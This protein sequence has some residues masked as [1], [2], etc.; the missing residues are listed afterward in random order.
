MKKLLFLL[1]VWLLPLFAFGSVNECL[2][3]VYFANGILTDEGNATANTILL[4]RAI[5]RD[6]YHLNI[7]DYN[8][9]IGD[10]YKAYNST[11]GSYWD[12]IESAAQKWGFQWLKDKLWDTVHKADLSLQIKH[13]KESIRMGH[14]VLAVAHSQGNLFTNDAYKAILGD[15]HDWWMTPYFRIV[16]VASPMH[17]KITDDTPEISWDNDLVA[18]LGLDLMNGRTYNPVRKIKWEFY[19]GVPIANR[20]ARPR[21]NYV[22]SNKL[23]E[24]YK[25]SWKAVEGLLQKFDSN[26]HAF[27]FYMGQPIKDGDTGEIFYNPFDENKTLQT[28][29]AKTKIM[30]AINNQLDDLEKVVSQYKIKENLGCLCKDKYVKME[31]RFGDV[32]LTNEIAKYK[33]RNFAGDGKGKV[34]SVGDQYVR[35]ACDGTKIEELNEG[36]TCY[37]LKDDASNEIGTITGAADIAD[38]LSGAV[39]VALDWENT[40][41]DL[42]L[43]VRWDA[44]E[45]DVKD[46]ECPK[47]HWVV[48]NKSSVK[49]GRYAVWVNLKALNSEESSVADNV[50]IDIQALGTTM[51]IVAVV[52]NESDY[53]IGHVA[54]I[55]IE[56]ADGRYKPK[57]EFIP[58]DNVYIGGGGGGG[59]RYVPHRECREEDDKYNCACM[60]C[61][62]KIIPYLEQALAGP[63]SGAAFKLYEASTYGSGLPLYTGETSEGESILTAGIIKV[64]TNFTDTLDDNKLYLIE[65]RG[66]V[67]VDSDDDYNLDDRSVVN[68]G[69]LRALMLGK[70]LKTHGYKINLLTEISYQVLK[71]KIGTIDDVQL[72]TELDDISQYLLRESIYEGNITYADVINWLP[73]LD[74]K[75]LFYDYDERFAP[76]VQKIYEDQDIYED[77]LALVYEPMVSPRIKGAY[78]K[79]SEDVQKNTHVGAVEIV[80]EGNS[81]IEAFTLSGEGSE[82]FRIDLHGN[83]YVSETASIDYESCQ[84]YHLGATASNADG[85]TTVGVT[86]DI[87]DIEDAPFAKGFTG[88]ILFGNTP[89]QTPVAKIIFDPGKAPIESMTL[90]GDETRYFDINASGD[91]TVSDF[92]LPVITQDTRFHFDV[93]AYN[94]YGGSQPVG[95]TLWVKPVKQ[96]PSLYGFTAHVDEHAP[97]NT[98]IHTVSFVSGSA[99]VDA[100][101]LSG[102][103]S[104]NFTVNTRGE[105]RVSANADLDYERR[106]SYSLSLGARNQFGL[107]ENVNVNILLNDVPDAATLSPFQASITE[108]TT[109]TEPLG[110]VQ[111]IRGTSDIVLF[112]LTGDGSEKFEVDSQGI[113]RVVPGTVFDYEEKSLYA[114]KIRAL[115]ASGYSIPVDFN[116]VIENVL[117]APELRSRTWQI[118]ENSKDIM[119]SGTVLVNEGLSPVKQMVVRD[120]KGN[121]STD[122]EVGLDGSVHVLPDAELDYE[123][124]ERGAT[125]QFSVVAYNDQG[126]SKSATLTINLNNLLDAPELQPFTGSIDENASSGTV[127]GSVEYN[128]GL[129]DIVQMWLAVPPGETYDNPFVIDNAGEIRL[130]GKIDYETRSNYTLFAFAKNRQGTS[131]PAMVTITIFDS[132]NDGPVLNSFNGT[133]S[134][135][136]YPGESVGKITYQEG[137]DPIVSMAL[138]GTGSENFKVDERG[139]ITLAENAKLDFES[140]EQYTLWAQAFSRGDSSNIVDV[141][142]TVTDVNEN[143]RAGSGLWANAHANI[144]RLEEDGNRTLLFTESTSNVRGDYNKTGLF[145]SHRLEFEDNRFYVYEINGGEER[146]IDHNGVLDE[147]STVNLGILHAVT[148]GEWVRKMQKP[149]SVNLMTDLFYQWLKDDID[150]GNYA[151]LE[152][153]LQD[154]YNPIIYWDIDGEYHS[155]SQNRGDGRDALV[156]DPVRNS[157][158]WQSIFGMNERLFMQKLLYDGEM[159]GYETYVQNTLNNRYVWHLA[160]Q[161]SSVMLQGSPYFYAIMDMPGQRGIYRKNIENNASML[162]EEDGTEQLVVDETNKLLYSTTYGTES[163]ESLAIWDTSAEDTFAKIAESTIRSN[164]YLLLSSNKEMLFGLSRDQVEKYMVADLSGSRSNRYDV[165]IPSDINYALLSEDDRWLYMANR[166]V[167]LQIYNAETMALHASLMLSG[168]IE[169]IRKLQN[170]EH[171]GILWRDASNSYFGLVNIADKNQPELN[172]SLDLNMSRVHAF[173]LNR[174]ET[175][176]FVGGYQNGT[177][178][179]IYQSDMG[180]FDFREITSIPIE[181]NFGDL[182]E[183]YL[184]EPTHRLIVVGEYFMYIYDIHDLGNAELIETVQLADIPS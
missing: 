135:D 11:H 128:P 65:A 62:A 163:E 88:G 3:D 68:K 183:I 72:R 102:E 85:N 33:I 134:E 89:S 112:E 15:S 44:G 105:V 118:D 147:N 157:G 176:L 155:P 143:A 104:E 16:S 82:D 60:P 48:L 41:A 175:L 87:L 28:D 138:S 114:L 146:D 101:V 97:A 66:G 137:L 2:T 95:I 73:T 78:L 123:D 111:Y 162:Q 70:D 181:H 124:Y 84:T 43:D 92:G 53:N 5:Q 161:N 110:Q 126:V 17:F 106:K 52:E 93:I 55:I 144:Y 46:I 158:V 83:I 184:Y 100:F 180:D 133:I 172:Y 7:K 79:V 113:V 170:T 149:L 164:S 12:I 171:L 98:L 74:K 132:E 94:R 50:V 150:S 30:T 90:I 165:Q 6:V 69:S 32:S 152:E 29:I 156:Y 37:I 42:D 19:D 63:L 129:S 151:A 20:V 179:K 121:I 167:G 22:R 99:P 31:H 145:A 153:K 26:V 142:I 14:R 10:V 40:D 141:N 54:D 166:N 174:D 154:S 57:V 25:G 77:A 160:K 86:I 109:V 91:I 38:V 130:S 47:E 139:N 61:S 64:D 122:I 35:A 115:N 39:T 76:V 23:N 108:N 168:I 24:I 169:R 119:L 140:Q 21:H 58:H 51:P 81:S 36:D 56:Y 131:L 8:K 173:T 136:A 182:V 80:S 127:I 159:D 107:S 75:L 120:S 178:V 27:T 59:S 9:N 49:E 13:Y 67:D 125:R 148:K 34:Y 96:T 71:E 116:V 117:D 103:G 177:V 18:D 4:K 1:F 45:Y